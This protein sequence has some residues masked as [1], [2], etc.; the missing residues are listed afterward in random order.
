M[1]N[2]ETHVCSLHRALYE[3]KQVPQA[4][5]S[6]IDN[7]LQK[8]G[9]QRS[10]A[11]HNLYFLSGEV[12]LILVLYVDDLFLTGYERPIKG[13]KSNLA[14][15]FEMKDLGL[16]HYFL[17]LEVWQRDGCF[18]IGQGKYAIEI[19]KRFRMED[20]NPMAIP[21]VSN[22]RKID[23]SGSDGFDPTLYCQLIGSLM[24]L[25]NRR[26]DIRFVV[27]SLSQF[28]VDT[29]RV[30]WPDAKHIL[31]YIRGTVEYGLVYERRGCIQ[32]AGFTDAD[33][34]GCV[35]DRKKYFRLLF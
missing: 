16:M 21:Q 28:M 6:R 12:P 1:E 19:L 10:E 25:V 24:Y 29:R 32:L 17:G 27:N 7:Y 4:W 33:C 22:W 30:H 26:P 2:R 20:C 15:E 13:Y 31:R 14:V 23:A 8:M 9:F 18:F 11:G 5:Y 35:E 34:V 3:L